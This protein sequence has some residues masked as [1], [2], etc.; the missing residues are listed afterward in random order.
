MTADLNAALR[1][2][3]RAVR[4]RQALDRCLVCGKP[5]EHSAVGTPLCSAECVGRF[6][7]LLLHQMAD[8]L[9]TTEDDVNDEKQEGGE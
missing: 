4:I 3:L 6:A 9:Y 1:R 2:L 8:R 5:A 7:D